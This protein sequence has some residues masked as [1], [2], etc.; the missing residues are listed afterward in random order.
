MRQY[1]NR[2]KGW[3]KELKIDKDGVITSFETCWT[4]VNVLQRDRT[5]IRLYNMKSLNSKTDIS[6]FINLRYLQLMS[7]FS[8]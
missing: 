4:A 2:I 3:K 7:Y 6:I 5:I 1:I 8:S